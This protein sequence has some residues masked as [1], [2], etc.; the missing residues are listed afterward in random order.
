MNSK[1][2]DALQVGEIFNGRAVLTESSIRKTKAVPP[3]NYLAITLADGSAQLSG[4]IWNYSKSEPLPTGVYNVKFS[5]GEYKGKKQ[6]D[7]AILE[8]AED[9]DQSEFSMQFTDEQH[10]HDALMDLEGAIDRMTHGALQCFA[11]ELFLNRVD[12]WKAATSA[13]SMHHVGVGGNLIHTYEVVTIANELSRLANSMGYANYT[14]LVVCGALLHDL[15]KLETYR[16][17][18]PACYMT[19]KGTMLDHVALGLQALWTSDAAGRYPSI[20]QALA[21]IIASHHGKLEFGCPV[22]PKTIEA[23]IVCTADGLSANLA[24]FKDA[25]QKAAAEKRP[26]N[27]TDRVFAAGNSVLPRR[28]YISKL[29]GYI[30]E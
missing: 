4:N 17:E 19:E 25:E 2:F 23:Q 22:I 27:L 3:R 8:Y 11:T 28:D 24:V 26:G 12:L 13:V 29:L 6:C 1:K 16:I 21:H 10:I 30:P 7:N 5:V 14:D 20:A 9:Q 15:G 18:G